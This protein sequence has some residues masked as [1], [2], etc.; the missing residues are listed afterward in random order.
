MKLLGL[1]IAFVPVGA[2]A[3]WRRQDAGSDGG[4]GLPASLSPPSFLES[5]GVLDMKSTRGERNNN[6]G[7]IRKSIAKWQ[8]K[9]I[10]PDP[11]FEAFATPDDGIRAMARLLQN[12]RV[13][14]GLTTVRG[15]IAKWA[16]STENN[17]AAYVLNV[18]AEL[19]VSPDQAIDVTDDA[20]LSKLV[21]AII[22]H[23]NGRVIYA[24]AQIDSAVRSA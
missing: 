18:A 16:P 10:G 23:E 6:P 5:A 14:Y 22:R 11:D 4:V 2:Y 1:L 7:N 8:G 3:F 20:V 13:R 9:T 24:D 19:N 17:T 21:R 12:Y 15:I